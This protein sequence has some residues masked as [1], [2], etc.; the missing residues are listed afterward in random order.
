M[1]HLGYMLIDPPSRWG[2]SI[3]DTFRFIRSIGYD[4]VELNLT[5]ELAGLLDQVEDAALANDLPVVSLL[6]G[7]AYGEGLCL[8][9]PDASIRD[10]TVERLVENMEAANRFGAILVV[11]LLQGLRSDEPD[12]AAAQARIV[13]CLQQVGR[14]AEA[15]GVDIVIEPVNHLQVGFNNSVGEVL[16]L[17]RD[18]GSTAFHPMVDTIHMNI[19]ETSL[20][21]PIHACGARLRH[22]HL[23]ESH[24]GLPGTGRIDFAAVLDALGGAGYSHFASVK[25]YRKAGLREAVEQSMAFF[26][27]LKS[28]QNLKTD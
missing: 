22:V 19:E 13:S 26:S 3:D 24:G 28:G 1:N 9:A 15:R 7:A 25:V 14:E 4:G 5:P 27:G 18:I 17:I 21:Q 10:R 8:C 12:P 16:R 11:G 2:G 6:T 23:C 20:V